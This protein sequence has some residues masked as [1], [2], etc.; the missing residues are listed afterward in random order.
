MNKLDLPISIQYFSVIRRYNYMY[1]DK[2]KYIYEI[3]RLEEKAYFLSRPRRFGKSLLLDTMQELFE[4]NQILFKDLWIEDKWNWSKTYPVLRFSFDAIEH[5]LPLEQALMSELREV[6]EPFEVEITAKTPSAGLKELVTKVFKSTGKSVVI[7]IDEY[8]RPIADYINAYSLEKAQK[9][10]DILKDFF[11]SLKKLSK[12]I[13]FLFITGVSKFARISIFS[14][15]NHLDDLTIDPRSH[16][17][18]GYTQAELEHYFKPY[19][20][21]MPED[22]L[23][24]MRYW[25]NGYSW[26]GNTWVYNPFSVLNFF[27]KRIYQNYWFHT[28]TPSFLARVMRHRF[29]YQLEKVEVGSDILEKFRLEDLTGLNLTSLLLQTGYLTI[30]EV[31]PY[32]KYVLDYPNQEV[33]QSF[34]EL[35]L[36]NYVPNPNNIPYQADILEA[37]DKGNLE[38]VR[39]VLHNLINSVP[40]Q[41]YVNNEEK[42]IHALVHLI[43][44]MAGSDVRSEVHTPKGR[45]DT[46][47]I[48][49]KGIF[50]FEFKLDESAD[51]A[52]KCIED[53]KYVEHLKHRNLPITGIGV[54]FSTKNKGIEQWKTQLYYSPTIS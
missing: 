22:T 16:A 13:R 30:K 43:F 25:Y 37:L 14:D 29:E 24:K 49:P 11:S 23:E 33:K 4:G 39:D 40:D 44:V 41:N 7:L 54:S 27:A 38:K 15:L 10:R 26:D 32:N 1:V 19:L 21:T 28:G 2:T 53:R 50:I 34:G 8:D 47:V 46:L 3:C 5:E 6:A 9:Q 20:D 17:I 36:E 45:I 52:L 12:Y 42:F 35:L 31:S 18:C 51:A 48:R